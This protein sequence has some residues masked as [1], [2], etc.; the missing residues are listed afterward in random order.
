MWVCVLV[1]VIV[2]ATSCG[3]TDHIVVCGVFVCCFVVGGC[4]GVLCFLCF[5]CWGCVGK[6][7]VSLD[8]VGNVLSA[9]VYIGNIHMGL[10]YKY[11]K[12]VL[13]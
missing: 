7:S 4:G 9:I 12:Q 10:L 6:R 2:P 1:C 5:C 8:F 3:Y 11:N 13:L